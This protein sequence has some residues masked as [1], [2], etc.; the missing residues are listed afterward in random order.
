MA[1]GKTVGK[2]QEELQNL[3]VPDYYTRALTVT[4]VWLSSMSLL[5]TGLA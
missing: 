4:S 1:A 5:P 3:Y 2:L